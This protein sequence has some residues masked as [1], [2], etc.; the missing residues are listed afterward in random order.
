[1]NSKLAWSIKSRNV[2]T[3]A[4]FPLIG[5]NKRLNGHL[6]VV[7]DPE[8]GKHTAQ[9]LVLVPSLAV[10]EELVEWLVPWP[11]LFDL[12]PRPPNRRER[13]P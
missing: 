8:V 6:P 2:G 10:E 1:M 3:G 11:W 12:H 5:Y 13:V 7:L 9:P 4:E